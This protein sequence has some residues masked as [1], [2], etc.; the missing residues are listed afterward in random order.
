MV[1]T[2]PHDPRHHGGVRETTTRVLQ[3]LRKMAPDPNPDHPPLINW[4]VITTNAVGMVIGLIVTAG[5][6]GLAYMGWQLPHQQAEILRGQAEARLLM[7]QS[8]KR[9][10]KIE[11]DIRGLDRRTTRLEVAR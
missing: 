7:Q 8:L 2:A 9:V 1:A 10:E 4:A 11:D 6:G 3:L 5:A